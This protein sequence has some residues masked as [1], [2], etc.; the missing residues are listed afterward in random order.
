MKWLA[1]L[2]KI[3]TAPEPDPTKPTEPG[4]VGSVAP[5]IAPMTK[6]DGD[7][8]AANDP[9]PEPDRWCWPHTPAW[10]SGEIDTFLARLAR[11]ADKGL[12]L[13]DAEALAEKLVAR[14]RDLDDRRYCPECT[15]HW[16]GRCA[17]KQAVLDVPFRC[18]WFNFGK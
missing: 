4:F 17:K 12:G 2:K 6:M 7:S 9:T 14:D 15:H 11:F 18:D 8:P 5:D 3:D 1:R 16:Q 13:D 10:N